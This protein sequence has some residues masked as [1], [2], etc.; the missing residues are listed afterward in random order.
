M[1]LPAKPYLRW[2]EQIT[3]II[4][5]ALL[6]L[7]TIG[8]AIGLIALVGSLWGAVA[9]GNVSHGLGREVV[10]GV[11]SLFI[12]IEL[13]RSLLGYFDHHRLRLTFILDAAIVFVIRELMI[14]LFE[15]K[16]DP[17]S[18]YALSVLLLVLGSLR[19]GSMFAFHQECRLDESRARRARRRP[20]NRRK[21]TTEQH[22]SSA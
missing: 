1:S 12:L 15:H 5:G 2:F 13:S 18:I 3:S 10:S 6:V 21:A 22:D 19:L 16:I 7:V 20:P 11:L 4:Y 9:G 8:I 14:G 17:S